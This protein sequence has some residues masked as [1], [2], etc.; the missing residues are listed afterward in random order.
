MP[1]GFSLGVIGAGISIGGMIFPNIG[2]VLQ[3][4]QKRFGRFDPLDAAAADAQQR[5]GGD[6]RGEERSLHY[7]FGH[8]GH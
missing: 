2:A 4:Y 8:F 7:A 1:S 3:A 5:G 6:Q